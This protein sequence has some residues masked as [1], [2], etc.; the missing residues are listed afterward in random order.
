M[1]LNK[2]SESSILGIYIPTYNR[3]KFL[4]KAIQSIISSIKFANVEGIPIFISD[5][6]DND[7]TYII[8]KEI[9]KLYPF[10]I[11]RK[12]KTNIGLDKNIF[13]VLKMGNTDFAWLMGDDDLMK[14]NAIS[15]VLN[16]IKQN[17]SGKENSKINLIFVNYSYIDNNYKNILKE[18]VVNIKQ[19]KIMDS[20]EFIKKY[21]WA[22]GF[23][24]SCIIKRKCIQNKDECIYCGN[25]FPHIGYILNCSQ[26]KKIYVISEPL[27]LNR[28]EN[29]NSSTWGKKAFEVY[30]GFEKTLLKFKNIYGDEIINIALRNSKVLFKH[31]SLIWIASKRADGVLN[32]ELWKKYILK[33]PDYNNFKKFISL[34]ISILPISLFKMLK[35]FTK[36]LPQ[37]LKKKPFKN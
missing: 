6:S 14:K 31:K 34:F 8:I 24:G 29:I 21:I 18:K 33:N 23:I 37:N 30:N 11:Y 5:N 19:D 35:F 28:S 13:K 10:I 15:V 7:E 27:I 2:V 4:K 9:Q 3:A 20:T 36:T 22:T 17:Y 26:K 12:N 1:N 32:Y 25:Y 16:I